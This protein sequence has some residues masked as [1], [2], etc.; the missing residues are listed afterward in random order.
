MRGTKVD[1][2]QFAVEIGRL[3]AHGLETIDLRWLAR[4]GYL[5]HAR[6]VTRTR[7]AERRFATT[8]N[9]AFTDAT[10]FVATEQGLLI[11]EGQGAAPDI[12]PFTAAAPDPS[13]R[14]GAPTRFVGAPRHA[15]KQ[16]GKDRVPRWD[17]ERRALLL[18][19]LVVKRFR[20]RSPNQEAVLDAFEEEGWPWRVYDPLSPHANHCAKQRLHWTISRLNRSQENNLIRFFSDGSAEA[21]CWELTQPVLSSGPL[22]R[23]ARKRRL[24]A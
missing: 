24:A 9:D 20:L 16:N 21:F 19:E 11:V 14:V 23:V 15:A 6:E 5:Q 22:M 1:A 7:D 13:L 2:W 8:R 3:L 18:G 17:R 10:C 12:I 4:M